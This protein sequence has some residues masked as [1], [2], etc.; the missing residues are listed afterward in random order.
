MAI[1]VKN[2]ASNVFWRIFITLVGVALILLGT[3]RIALFFLGETTTATIETRRVGGSSDNFK[4]SMRYEWSVDFSFLDT[5]G[6]WHSGHTTRRGGDMGVSVEKTVYYLKAAP[7][8]NSLASEVEPNPGQL[9]LPAL[10]TL[11]ILI[12]NRKPKKGAQT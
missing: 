3:S 12:M 10:G 9:I 5:D 8:I 7:F 6:V 2:K 11:L 4:P 1:K